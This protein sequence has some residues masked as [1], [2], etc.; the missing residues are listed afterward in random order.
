MGRG[1]LERA[2]ALEPAGDGRWRGR[3]SAHYESANGTFGG[4][5]AALALAAMIQGGSEHSRPASLTIDYLG[6]IAPGTELTLH[7]HPVSGGR[8]IAF[9]RCDVLDAKDGHPLA[10]ASAVLAVRRDTDGHVDAVAPPAPPPEGIDVIEAAPGPMGERTTV[11]PVHGFPP[12]AHPDTRSLA[13]VRETSGRP[14]DHLQLAYLADHRPPRSFFWSEGPRPS[15]TLTMSVWFHATDDELDDV[16][17]D[18]VL[19]E[20]FGVRGAQGT[21]EE[22]LRLWSRTGALLASSVQLCWYR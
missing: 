3:A 2:L 5:T 12:F 7:V 22:H 10:S 19:S 21:S 18:E 13:W 4:F 6:Q 1:D 14:V 11:R 20:A 8:S 9:R 17:D 15:A 16:G